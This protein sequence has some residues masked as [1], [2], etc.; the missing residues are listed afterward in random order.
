MPIWAA[1]RPRFLF[2]LTKEEKETKRRT[3]YL[4]DSR[5]KTKASGIKK[6]P[7]KMHSSA[8]P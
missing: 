5:C 4:S 7:Q 6:Q 3:A 1:A 2:L 8:T